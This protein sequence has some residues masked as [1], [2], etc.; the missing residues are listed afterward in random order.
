MLE[1]IDLG[2]KRYEPVLE[3]QR[4]FV[5]ERKK[6]ERSD[7]L[8]LVEHEPVY[9]LGRSATGKNVLLSEDALSGKGVDLVKIGRGGDVTFHGP[10][11]IVGYPIIDLRERSLKVV[12]LVDRIERSIG[13]TLL[14]FGIDTSFSREHRGVWAGD[15]KVAAIGIRITRGISMH[16]F[17]LNV[18]TDLQYYRW[19][20]PC[21]ISDK[22]VTSMSALVPGITVD[23]VKKPLIDNFKSEFD[24]EE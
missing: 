11:Q 14:H 18:T 23:D 19:I 10:G 15:E 17:A 6:G 2:R 4:R 16:G 21:G 8:I 12:D 1:V 9:T 20:V 5:E 13:A 24:Y 22:G 7:T 3:M